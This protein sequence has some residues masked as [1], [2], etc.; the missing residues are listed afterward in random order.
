MSADQRFF[1]QRYAQA[2]G[3]FTAAAEAAGL[4]VQS[5]PHPLLGRDGERLAL[6]L[7]LIHI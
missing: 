3:L 7:S 4:D 1:A 5:H 6:D 2:R